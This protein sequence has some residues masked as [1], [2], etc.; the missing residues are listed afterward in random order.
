MYQL[1]LYLF[2]CLFIIDM[3]HVFVLANHSL[4]L[5]FCEPPPPPPPLDD[6]TFE[7]WPFEKISG[8]LGENFEPLPRSWDLFRTLPFYIGPGT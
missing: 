2:F 7:K 5:V 8:G 4:Q 1:K 3:F 6:V